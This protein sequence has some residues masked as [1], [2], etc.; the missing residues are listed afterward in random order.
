MSIKKILLFLLSSLFITISCNEIDP[1]KEIEEGEITENIYYNKEIG[2]KMSIPNGWEITSQDV[3]K[4]RTEDGMEKLQE[5]IEAEY[6]FSELKHLI[7]FQKD[8]FHIFQ[9]TSEPFEEEYVGEWK[10]N[11]I[12]I[13]QLLYYT[14]SNNGINIDTSSSVQTIDSVEFNVSHI[15]MYGPKGNIILYQDMYSTYINGFDF[16]VNLNYIDGKKKD[17]MYRAWKN[18]TFE[19]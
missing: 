5:S 8:K 6:D 15:T 4:K 13:N 12:Q 14:Y 18:S 3:L 17:E 16:S 1:N 11:S 10:E 2:W 7:N 9:S 19:K